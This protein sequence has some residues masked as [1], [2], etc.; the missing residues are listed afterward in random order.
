MK[1]KRNRKKHW[2][3]CHCPCGCSFS[4]LSECNIEKFLAEVHEIVELEKFKPFK[5]FAYVKA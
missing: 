2:H 3:P 1:K 4:S 5:V